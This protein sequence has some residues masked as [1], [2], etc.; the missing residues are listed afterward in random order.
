MLQ[1]VVLC[2]GSGTRLWPVSRKAFPKQFAELVGGR[3]L[4]SLTL[5]RVAPLA[6]SQ[7]DVLCVGAAEH[8]FLLGDAVAAAGCRSTLILEPCPRSTAAAMALAALQA[9]DPQQLQLFCPADHHIPDADAF[10]GMVVRAQ[11]T[12]L[13]GAIVVFGVA[14]TFASTAYGYIERGAPHPHGGH[15]VVRFVE[16]P[17]ADRA[18]QLLRGGHVD[19]NAGIF[20]CRADVL[21]EAMERHAPDILACCRDAMRDAHRAAGIVR[22]RAVPM[23]GCR[24]ESIDDAV[25]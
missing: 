3:S 19:W 1:P 24:S 2:G 16:K 23:Q 11:G 8:H 21:L 7:G 20:L 12:A 13:A 25:M 4:L 10:R 9:Q 18:Q 22:P 17:T 6:G 14:P 5:D 15:R